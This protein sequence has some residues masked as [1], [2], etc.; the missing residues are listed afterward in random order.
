MEIDRNR[1]MVITLKYALC[2]HLY[3]LKMGA[4]LYGH[5]DI[6]EKCS[7]LIDKTPNI[8]FDSV[9]GFVRCKVLPPRNL[10]VFHP[11]GLLPYRV[12]GKMLFALCWSSETFSQATCTHNRHEER[13]FED[14]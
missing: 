3:V 5:L 4:F 9:E 2:I 1:N 10:L 7:K 13:E 8:N 12:K 14:T 6:G 11:V